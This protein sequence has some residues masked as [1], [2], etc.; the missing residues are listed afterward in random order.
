MNYYYPTSLKELRE[1]IERSID[2]GATAFKVGELMDKHG[3]NDWL[4]P[5][6]DELGPFIQVQIADLTNLLEAVYNFYHF[7]SP[8][9]TIASLCLFGALILITAFTDSRYA[10]KIF[11]FTVGLNFFICWPVSSRFP[12]YRLLV[13][14]WKWTLWDVPTHAEWCFQYLQERAEL[15][16][17][18]IVAH[19]ADDTSIRMGQQTSHV[20]TDSDS[21]ISFHSAESTPQ[22][23]NEINILS[24]GCTYQHTPGRFIIST[25]GIRFAPLSRLL[26]SQP[27]KEPFSAL[28]EMSKR[29]THNSLLGSLAKVTTE[30]DKLE[31]RFR[32]EHAALNM[33]GTAGNVVLLE[34]LRGRDKAFN[35]II[36]F[37]G[38]R[39]QNLQQR[40]ERSKTDIAP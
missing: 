18:A 31:L 36:G 26:P 4:G 29:Q 2:R 25:K 19:D 21:E 14:I 8:P 28:L 3:S 16:K 13:S 38:A 24:F 20:D 40:A 34:N 27:F 15:A 5:L 23:Q 22:E 1:G 39:W 9:A 6:L 30:M 33:T 35:A 17:E 32:S 11:W 10:M 37:S 7:R 12:K